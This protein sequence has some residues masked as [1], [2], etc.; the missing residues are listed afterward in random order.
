MDRRQKKTRKAIFNAFL[1]LLS[2]RDFNTISVQE[3]ID[4]ADVG[5]ATFYAHFETK[6]Y[7]LKSICE[8]LFSHV[9]SSALG[10]SDGRHYECCFEKGDMFLHLIRHLQK[11]DDN[12]L[13]LLTSPNN[14]L[15]LRYFKEALKEAVSRSLEYEKIE[16]P[17]EYL[18]NHIASSFV[19]TVIWWAKNGKKEAPE[20]LTEYLRTV[21]GEFSIN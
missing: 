17:K 21:L 3:I 15:F 18:V 4:K 10:K 20:K 9:V 12:V 16:V 1:E 11:N 7:L 19:E 13:Q 14:E 2:Q 5:R 8:E 6:D